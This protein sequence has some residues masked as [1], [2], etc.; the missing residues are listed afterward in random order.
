MSSSDF[1]IAEVI[2]AAAAEVN[3]SRSLEDTLEAIAR[4]TLVSVPGFD[5]VGVSI[6]H[7]GG[8]IETMAGTDQLVW[9][10]DA[11]QYELDEGPCVQAI[12][13]QRVVVVDHA[14]HDQRWPRFTPIAAK[15][16][17]RSQLAVQLFVE[18]E[19]LGGLNLYS[20]SSDEVA[21]DAVRS[22][23]LFATHAAIALGHARHDD[24]LNQAL[25]SR[26]AIG[27]ALGILMERYQLD[28]DR[29]FQFMVRVSST[30]NVKLRDVAQEIVTS[31]DDR[32]HPGGVGSSTHLSPRT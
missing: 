15:R 31:T 11:A 3:T 9:D 5:H 22:A 6:H 1:T 7:R 12:R 25:T 2:T 14:R 4:A 20:T 21:E 26:K 23:E 28:E 19:R 18:D 30:G 13:E 16:G 27:Q 17:V 29:A 32:Y 10:L 24:Q 8:R